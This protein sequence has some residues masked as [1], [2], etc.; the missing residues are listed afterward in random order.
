MS[1]RVISMR[2]GEYG[3]KS[4]ADEFFHAAEKAREAVETM[5]DLAC[6]MEEKYG[7]R[8]FGGRGDYGR[9][10][11]MWDDEM[12]YGDRRRRDSMGRYR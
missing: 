10:D 5:H 7:E 1:Y 8:Y 2:G 9:R 6:E 11:E 3:R 12:R 4:E